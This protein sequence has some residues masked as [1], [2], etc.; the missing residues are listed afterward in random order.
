[1]LSLFLNEDPAREKMSEHRKTLK[2]TCQPKLLE[3]GDE[4]LEGAV[5]AVHCSEAKKKVS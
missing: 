1:M 3:E 2:V 4:A 5:D